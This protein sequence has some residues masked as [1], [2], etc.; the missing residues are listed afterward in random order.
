M[1]SL[2]KIFY[3]IIVIILIASIYQCQKESPST[4]RQTERMQSEWSGYISSTYDASL[5]GNPCESNLP[6][7][8]TE[9]DSYTTF[10]QT[11]I[12]LLPAGCEVFARF[13]KWKRCGKRFEF[14]EGDDFEF[15][16]G[17]G[18]QLS[19]EA[20]RQLME[21]TAKL[22]KR[23]K[24]RDYLENNPN[25]AVE[26]KTYKILCDQLCREQLADGVDRGH[27][28]PTGG[29]GKKPTYRYFYYKCGEG[30]CRSEATYKLVTGEVTL[31]GYVI[32][33]YGD[34]I[35]GPVITWG[36]RRCFDVVDN[37]PCK[38]RCD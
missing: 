9:D 10:T 16:V 21:I 17:S 35:T 27:P 18:C 38:Q 33:P 6:C 19:A 4:G 22:L 36:N 3:S 23:V 30:C 34:C 15:L 32:R 31:V 25:E 12:P 7:G 1:K 26:V 28:L 5:E 14:F 2:I 13:S 24:I 20:I 8:W 29:D 11:E 37:V